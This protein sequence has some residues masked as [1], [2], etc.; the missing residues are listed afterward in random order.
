MVDFF[1]WVG[2]A[3]SSAA[4]AVSASPELPSRIAQEVIPWFSRLGQEAPAKWLPYITSGATCDLVVSGPQGERAPC[5][6]AAVAS[7]DCCGRRVCLAHCRIDSFG[8]AICYGCI[9]E[10]HARRTGG[11][12]HDSERRQHAPPPPPSP[13]GMTR[14]EALKILKLKASATPEEIKAAWKAASF[15]WHPDRAKAADRE[16]MTE[17][18]KRI[19]EA[20]EVLKR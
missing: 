6:H 16:K 15:R 4:R 18:L 7:C 20:Y 10:L 19:N 13:A 5:G 17:R 3:V 8:D 11:A 2:G 12:P 14:A 1:N 9:A